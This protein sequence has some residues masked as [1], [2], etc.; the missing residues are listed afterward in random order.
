MIIWILVALDS[1]TPEVNA[2]DISVS[3]KTIQVVRYMQLCYI[4][5]FT[6]T[7]GSATQK[8]QRQAVKSIL[9]SRCQ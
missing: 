9:S 5:T 7:E 1:V 8:T 3:S 6:F 4:V 2:Q